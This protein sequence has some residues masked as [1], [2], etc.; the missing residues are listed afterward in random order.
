M[1]YCF[2]LFCDFVFKAFLSIIRWK[3][4]EQNELIGITTIL[5]L[6]A[7]TP[8]HMCYFIYLNY[9]HW[10]QMNFKRLP[11]ALGVSIKLHSTHRSRI[12]TLTAA[13]CSSS[14]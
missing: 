8:C 7:T 13:W 3:S 1:S 12:H 4:P 9:S 11:K 14:S 10:C 5:S 2:C 6:S